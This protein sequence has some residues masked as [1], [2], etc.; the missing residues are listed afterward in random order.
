MVIDVTR[1]LSPVFWAMAALLVASA[2]VI[3]LGR[4]LG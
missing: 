4:R 3:A 1:E 2:A